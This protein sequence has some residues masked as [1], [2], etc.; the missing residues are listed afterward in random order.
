MSS[1]WAGYFSFY[2]SLKQF[3]PTTT[4]VQAMV[5]FE[6]KQQPRLVN[7]GGLKERTKSSYNNNDYICLPFFWFY[8]FTAIKT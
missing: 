1:I 3:H 2:T 7:E 5:N 4:T 6:F 8:I